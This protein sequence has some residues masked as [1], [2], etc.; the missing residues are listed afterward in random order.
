MSK[1][2]TAA[3]IA[4]LGMK[5]IA[6][7]KHD[8]TGLIVIERREL[9]RLLRETASKAY[10]AGLSAASGST[11]DDPEYGPD[12]TYDAPKTVKRVATPTTQAPRHPL[13]CT[14]DE[15]AW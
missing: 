9:D 10:A 14:C 2:L 12:V 15:C 11:V 5:E 7:I 4:E 1:P 8:M 13:S 3:Q 6:W